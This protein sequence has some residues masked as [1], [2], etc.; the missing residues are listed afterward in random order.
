MTNAKTFDDGNALIFCRHYCLCK[1][2]SGIHD[3]VY[4]NC[5]QIFRNSFDPIAKPVFFSGFPNDESVRALSSFG[6]F[7]QKESQPWNRSHFHAGNLKRKFSLVRI[8]KKFRGQ[9]GASW[10][11]ECPSKI[12]KPVFLSGFWSAGSFRKNR[13][14]VTPY[15]AEV[16]KN[17]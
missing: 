8:P 1:G 14:F 17:A 15:H 5:G 11:K 2:F 3:I 10:R 12:Q 9:F 16:S 6:S 7:G 4:E 13:S